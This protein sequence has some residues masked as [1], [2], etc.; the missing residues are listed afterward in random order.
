MSYMYHLT[1]AH[2]YI[3]C[4][5][6]HSLNDDDDYCSY[7]TH[8]AESGECQ[9][10]FNCF[11]FATDFCSDCVSGPRH[12][13]DGKLCNL[14]GQVCETSNILKG[15]FCKKTSNLIVHLKCVN[16]EPMT[17]I[18]GMETSDECLRICQDLGTSTC[19][20]YTHFEDTQECIL[21][22]NCQEISSSDCS[23]CVYGQSDCTPTDDTSGIINLRS[24]RTINL[25]LRIVFVM[26]LTTIL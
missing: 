26:L 3:M 11:I 6:Q 8:N 7:F 15:V 13:E 4:T 1:I 5:T 12:C 23:D 2:Q 24:S 22:E 20:W 16:E 10:F 9:T 18:S 21:Y 14:P 17:I 19:V 25:N